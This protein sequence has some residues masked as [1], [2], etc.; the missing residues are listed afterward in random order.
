MSS[1]DHDEVETILQGY[2]SP[3]VTDELYDMGK[4]LMEEC[5][6][7]VK[8]LDSKSATIAGYSG[9]VIGLMV[10]TFPIWTSALDKWAVVL[11]TL[12]SL[13]GLV[14]GA[15]ALSSTWPK[16][17]LLPSD[18]DW[19]EADGLRDPDR[20]KR[21]YVSS[22]HISIRS[23][24]EVN[25]RKV[26]KIKAAQVCLGIMVFCLLLGLGDQTYR[27][28]TRPAQSSSG[29]EVSMAAPSGRGSASAS[30]SVW[31]D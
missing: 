3:R 22:L 6:A 4:V 16:T 19:L 28:M 24:E 13:V 21:Y 25:A 14:G 2:E 30:V 1:L 15:V 26:S 23:H 20:L 7:R 27:V 17:F 10:S 18:T 31:K 11:V 12:G 29:H 9:A 5:S 8:Y